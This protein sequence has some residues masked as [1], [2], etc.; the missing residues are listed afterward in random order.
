MS[1]NKLPQESTTSSVA[2]EP[3]AGIAIIGLFS[4]NADE[5]GVSADE[6]EVLTDFLGQ[7]GLFDDYSDEDLE[8]LTH[9][10]TRLLK[11]ED[12]DELIALAI[13]SL[14]DEN[15]RE[16]AYLAAILVA[17]IDEEILEPEQEFISELQTALNISD[18][19]AQ[20]L[21]DEVFGEEDEENE[22]D[23]EA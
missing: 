5:K 8:N 12:A 16:A 3:E 2:L 10:V 11:E 19:R 20:E 21:I 6:Q 7:I 22:E 14:P 18:D 23:E 4:A 15:Y 9:E 17:G 13:D 1:K